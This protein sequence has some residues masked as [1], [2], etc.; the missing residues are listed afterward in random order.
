MRSSIC[1]ERLAEAGRFGE[2]TEAGLA[3]IR[4][5]PLRESAR[6]ALIAAHL[7]EGKPAAG[8]SA[9]PGVRQSLLEREAR[10]PALAAHGSA[11]R[12]DDGSVTH[13]GRRLRLE[14]IPPAVPAEL[15]A[16]S[17]GTDDERVTAG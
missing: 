11:R 17:T 13:R 2:A 9:V 12:P 3:S 14:E 4:D 8:A 16:A 1:A 7:A 5:D 15:D 6:R 10:H